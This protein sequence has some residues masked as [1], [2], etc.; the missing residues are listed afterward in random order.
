MSGVINQ[1][2]RPRSNRTGSGR[3]ENNSI[4]IIISKVVLFLFCMS[5]LSLFIFIFR[6]F[7]FFVLLYG[8]ARISQ[9][10]M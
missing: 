6:A 8:G 1:E 3:E 10:K 5:L 7:G 9:Q 4:I 2:G